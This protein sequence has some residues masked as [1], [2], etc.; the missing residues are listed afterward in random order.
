[1]HTP[2]HEEIARCA[3]QIWQDRGHPAGCDTEIWL[4]AER[5]LTLQTA[6][7]PV[8]LGEGQSD[9]AQA[10][11]ASEQ[12]KAALAPISPSKSAP[13]KHVPET[14]KPLW[15]KPHSR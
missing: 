15:K 5:Q 4:E 6:G 2:T 9:H 13:P 10:E 1:M 7:T 12:R 14:G 8:T 11:K 3:E